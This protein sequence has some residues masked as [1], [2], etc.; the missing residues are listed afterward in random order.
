MPKFVT[1]RVRRAAVP[2]A[3]LLLAVA[4]AVPASAASAPTGLYSG[5]GTCPLASAAMQ[6]TNNAVV[7]C[8]VAVVNGGSFAIGSTLVTIPTTEP[9]TTTFGAYWPKG[10]PTVT[11]PHGGSAEIFSTVPPT[12]G[13]E[14]TAP[15]IDV[16]IPGLANFL[17]GVTSAYAQVELAGPITNFAPLADGQNYPLFQLPIKLHLENPFLGSSCYLGSDS[18]PI[19]VQPTTG[20]TA[21]PAPNTP[22]TGNPGTLSLHLDPNGYRTQVV[23]FTGATLVDNS[24]AV[25]GAN[26]CGPLGLFDG[27]ID[28]LFN[29]PS[30]AGNNTV[31]FSGVNTSLAIDTSIADLT[32]AISASEK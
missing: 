13:N 16:P 9:I 31:V 26:G 28:A 4:A 25:P 6:S 1:Q 17:P 19:L 22:I 7:S 5:M 14:L 18:A 23:G 3:G 8:V 32:S 11:F 30:A 24:G 12:D 27:I 20:T 10:G 2:A 29:L 15:A 21:P